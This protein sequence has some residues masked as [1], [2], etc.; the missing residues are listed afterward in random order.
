MV[1]NI[2]NCTILKLRNQAH[3]VLIQ[4]PLPLPGDDDD[5]TYLETVL[6]S[7]AIHV[8]LQISLG[9]QMKITPSVSFPAAMTAS[10]L[11]SLP[12]YDSNDT[13]LDFN[14]QLRDTLI[15]S[16][17]SRKTFV[18]AFQSFA[19]VLEYDAVDFA[20][21]SYSVRVMHQKMYM[22]CVVEVRLA[23]G[24]PESE[25]LVMLHFLQQSHSIPLENIYTRIK[26]AKSWGVDKIAKEVFCTVYKWID[27]SAFSDAK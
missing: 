15:H 1:Q 2:E 23:V 6:D 16:W 12:P 24:F 9:V 17:R 25:P 18:Q 27:E 14:S 7:A 3:D 19:A 4:Y 11:L 22:I 10:R 20:F 5:M 13:P 21:L 26:Q 8:S